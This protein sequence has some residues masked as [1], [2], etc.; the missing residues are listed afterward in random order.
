M[1]IREAYAG[2][3]ERNFQAL[4]NKQI[5]K[6]WRKAEKRFFAPSDEVLEMCHNLALELMGSGHMTRRIWLQRH[7]ELPTEWLKNWV[8]EKQKDPE[9]FWKRR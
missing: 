8:E 7:L 4:Y 2:K 9:N 3:V 1:S 6:A 5:N